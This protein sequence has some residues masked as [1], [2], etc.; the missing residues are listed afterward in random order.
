MLRF[1]H[2]FLCLLMLGAAGYVYNVKYQSTQYATRIHKLKSEIAKEHI[3]INALNAEWAYLNRPDYLQ[4]LSERHLQLKPLA[5][6]EV[7]LPLGLKDRAGM[8][9]DP[10]SK[11]LD[12]LERSQPEITVTKIK[13][14]QLLASRPKPSLF[15]DKMAVGSVIKK[16]KPI[17]P[18]SL[19][20]LISQSY[21][22]QSVKGKPR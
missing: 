7:G 18:Q 4:A 16:P 14:P 3:E 19:N 13:P 17:K 22:T 9:L 20:D 21:K 15:V 11:L 10:I 12:A 1:A 6:S 2:L 5:L 8:P